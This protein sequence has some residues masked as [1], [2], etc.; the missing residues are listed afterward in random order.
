VKGAP[1]TNCLT[2]PEAEAIDRIWD[3]PRN[4]KGIKIWFGLDRGTDFVG[5]FPGFG[6]DGAVPF[7]FG[8]IQFQWD[9]H[10]RNFNWQTVSEA[11][12]PQVAQDGSRNIADVTDTFGPL[13]EF[14]EHGKMIT[15]VGG[16]DHLI[17]PRG[18]INYYRLTAARYSDD[19]N[20]PDFDNLQRF[21]RLFRAPG[22]AHCG[23]GAGPSPV[24]A[25]G[26]LVN[27][28]EHGVAPDSLLAAGGSAAPPSGR[29]RPLC[30][31]P[32][33]AIYK[34]T[35]DINGAAKFV[36]GGNL[37]THA[38]VCADVLV[39]YKHEVHGE[40]DYRGTGVNPGL[41]ERVED[42]DDSK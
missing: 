32:K 9:E 6:L 38:T 10:D 7:F 33:T 26:A 2:A 42:D 41:C 23:G 13:D 5:P 12:Y 14:K 19:G 8:V 35:G 16:N 30:P 22:V 1:G 15:W 39:K 40:L 25:F 31:Y 4:L 36:C 28:V 3:G 27:W 37:E 21:C 29:T 17:F 24:N 20:K 11:G 18:V 34:G